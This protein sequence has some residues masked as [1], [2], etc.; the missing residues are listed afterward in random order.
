M[1]LAPNINTKA[2]INDAMLATLLTESQLILKQFTQLNT[3]LNGHFD[4]ME[5][6]VDDVKTTITSRVDNLETR[7][8]IVETKITTL[9]QVVQE[10]LEAHSKDIE[11][12]REHISSLENEALLPKSQNVREVFLA[13]LADLKSSM[14]VASDYC[15]TIIMGTYKS[16]SQMMTRTDAPKIV[17][18]ALSN[19]ATQITPLG[20]I[21]VFV[22]R[23]MT[24]TM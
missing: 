21:R 24:P 18:E 15:D 9:E 2:G 16:R 17:T 11:D 19:Q 20:N 14:Y 13:A 3:Q 23:F 8:N 4:T 12:F 22:V 1:I 6:K 7:V 10:G 5:T